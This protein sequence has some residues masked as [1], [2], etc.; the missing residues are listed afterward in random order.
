MR[1]LISLLF[2]FSVITACGEDLTD[3]LADS[4][5]TA[6]LTGTYDCDDIN[7][8]NGPETGTVSVT[9]SIG[10]S[11]TLVWST[12]QATES[13]SSNGSK[14]EWVRDDEFISF[15]TRDSVPLL[16]FTFGNSNAQNCSKR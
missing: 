14:V 12:S 6:G 4:E 16:S 9:Q 8:G 7:T 5:L 1:A 10:N 3:I 13:F 2:V 15:E 11:L